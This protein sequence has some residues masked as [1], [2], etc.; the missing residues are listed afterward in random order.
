MSALPNTRATLHMISVSQAWHEISQRIPQP[1]SSTCPLAKALGRFT[2]TDIQSDIDSPPFDKSVVDGFAIRLADLQSSQ[3]LL[4]NE[5]VHAGQTPTQPV[6]TGTATQIMTGAP[7]PAGTEA[8]VMIEDCTVN[9][10]SNTVAVHN[11]TVTL[12]SHIMQQGKSLSCGNVV[13]TAGSKIR[14][15][16]IGLLAEVGCAE[17]PVATQ[18]NVAIICTGDELVDVEQHPQAGQIRN[19]NEALLISLVT[20]SGG[21]AIPL[22]IGRDNELELSDKIQQGLQSDVLLLSGGVSMGEKDLV[23]ALLQQAHVTEVFHKVQLKPGKPLWFGQA[24]DRQQRTLVF[25]LPGNPV[26][27]LVCYILFVAPMIRAYQQGTRGD[28]IQPDSYAELTAPHT[29]HGDR[30]T[31]HP[32]RLD[33]ISGKWSVT[34]LPWSGSADQQALAQA[35]CLV[36]FQPPQRE[37]DVGEQISVLP[38][39]W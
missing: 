6:K 17:V 29:L 37:Y 14:P 16:E 2:A 38:F 35:N 1:T 39:P 5:T 10:A 21:K 12:G 11:T 30:P 32:G 25:G 28:D 33:W 3:T 22:G 34:P 20:A 31:Y 18:P 23:P 8:V 13:I 19:S 24:E 27:S 15:V 7:I 36:F 9:L 26:S 4:I